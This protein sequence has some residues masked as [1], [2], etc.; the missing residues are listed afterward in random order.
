VDS[1][2]IFAE[3]FI[4]FAGFSGIV[5]ALRGN[6][7]KEWHEIDR[8]RLVALIASS[9]IGIFSAILP[10]ALDNLEIDERFVWRISCGF[11]A[12]SMLV[13]FAWTIRRIRQTNAFAHS[14]FSPIFIIGASLFIFP[15]IAILSLSALAVYFEANIGLFGMGLLA[16]LIV[17]SGMFV[18]LLRL[19]LRDA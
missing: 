5:A 7:D 14:D 2:D 3:L 9:I 19:V 13:M 12:T 6:R 16:N 1:L 15:L 10:K 4:G 8:T 11:I 18:L 17:C